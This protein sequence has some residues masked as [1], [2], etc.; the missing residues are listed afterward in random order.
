M[1][2]EMICA[3]CK[4]YHQPSCNVR[5]EEGAEP[6]HDEWCAGFKRGVKK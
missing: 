6:K 1:A 2:K 4:K 3:N 5:K